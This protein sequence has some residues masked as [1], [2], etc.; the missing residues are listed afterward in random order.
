MIWRKVFFHYLSMIKLP[1]RASLNQ[2]NTWNYLL[3]KSCSRTSETMLEQLGRRCNEMRL[4]VWLPLELK[5]ELSLLWSVEP[6]NKVYCCELEL[7]ELAAC[8]RISQTFQ[9]HF[10]NTFVT[11][12]A[13]LSLM[14]SITIKVSIDQAISGGFQSW[15][16]VRLSRD[17]PGKLNWLV[18]VNVLA[19]VDYRVVVIVSGQDPVVWDVVSY[20]E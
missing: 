9:H 3:I 1:Y 17:K 6:F 5:V 2:R 15:I 13:M 14:H 12:I 8:E 10:S 19:V 18:V 4:N 16:Q 20:N 7:D 11:S